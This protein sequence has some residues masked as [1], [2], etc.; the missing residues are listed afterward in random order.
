MGNH[1]KCNRTDIITNEE[2]EV[3][4]DVKEPW[5]WN[6]LYQKDHTGTTLKTYYKKLKRDGYVYCLYCNKEMCYECMGVSAIKYHAKIQKHV[7]K[8][9]SYKD[10][11][12]TKLSAMFTKKSTTE[13]AFNSSNIVEEQAPVLHATPIEDRTTSLEC[14]ILAWAAQS[15]LPWTRIPSLVTLIKNAS[16]DIHALNKLQLSASSAKRKLV[17][18]LAKEFSLELAE[19]LRNKI[20][21]LN[22]DEATNKN[23]K[24]KLFT[25]LV[26][27]FSS[28][29]GETRIHHLDTIRVLNCKANTM[30]A[31]LE[32]VFD[33][34]DPDWE[35][36]LAMMTDNCPAMKGEINGLEKQV[37]EKKQPNCHDK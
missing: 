11:K 30:L 9:Q 22:L 21:C 27:Y 13:S 7:N 20:Y 10:Q 15:N 34:H 2:E 4:E 19:V 35:N 24:D 25:I 33:K 28:E 6:W 36:L 32:E 3:T 12:Q 5:R 14:L 16:I 8:V 26:S 37:K 1:L 18:G 31:A 23:N 17:D 29:L